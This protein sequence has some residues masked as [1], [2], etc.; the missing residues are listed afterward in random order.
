MPPNPLA[1][2]DFVTAPVALANRNRVT[3]PAALANK[4]RVI[5]TKHIATQKN[6][7]VP[8]KWNGGSPASSPSPASV[9]TYGVTPTYDPNFIP[10]NVK[11]M[12]DLIREIDKKG[13]ITQKNGIFVFGDGIALLDWPK[14]D[15][16]GKLWGSFDFKSWMEDLSNLTLGMSIPGVPE[17]ILLNM[18]N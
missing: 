15:L 4:N 16:F 11:K 6:K 17:K 13:G 2:K 8:Y 10:E 14:L 3:T 12:L 18:Q 5:D 1:N 7:V 9:G